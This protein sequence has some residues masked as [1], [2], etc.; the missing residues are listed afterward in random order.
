M[1]GWGLG[2]DDARGEDAVSGRACAD[3]A[4]VAGE[5]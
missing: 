5:L 4:V 3:G 2:R 1:G